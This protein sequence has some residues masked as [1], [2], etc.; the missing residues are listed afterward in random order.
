MRMDWKYALHLPL[1]YAC[2]N[3]GVLSEFRDRLVA[4]KAVGR[5]FKALVA[6]IREMGMIQEHGK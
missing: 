2:F 3:F 5:V 6:Q 1:E 4:G